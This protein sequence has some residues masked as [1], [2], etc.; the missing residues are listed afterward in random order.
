MRS[1]RQLYTGTPRCCAAVARRRIRAAGARGDDDRRP[2]RDL[3]SRLAARSR[4]G[5]GHTGGRRGSGQSFATAMAHLADRRARATP[6]GGKPARAGRAPSRGRQAPSG[7][8]R[9]TSR[10]VRAVHD[11]NDAVTRTSSAASCPPTIMTEASPSSRPAAP[12]RIGNRRARTARAATGRRPL[13][14]RVD[15]CDDGA[16]RPG[17]ATIPAVLPRTAVDRLAAGY[18]RVP[19]RRARVAGHGGSRPGCAVQSRG[20][21]RTR[22]RAG[23]LRHPSASRLPVAVTIQDVSFFA[24]PEWFRLREVSA[25]AG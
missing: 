9:R 4:G 3:A 5:C 23:L 1:G 20:T 24:H 8:T 6:T 15:A 19:R 12:L 11:G 10:R 25:A 17:A 21:V 2:R 18:G 13:P 7:C 16:N 22:S 14:R